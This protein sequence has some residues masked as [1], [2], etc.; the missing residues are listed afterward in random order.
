MVSSLVSFAKR[1]IRECLPG[2]QIANYVIPASIDN[3]PSI[4]HVDHSFYYKPN[5]DSPEQ[6]QIKVDAEQIVKSIVHM[7][8]TS[9]LEY[10]PEPAR[11]PA[12]FCVI[13]RAVT[14]DILKKDY[15]NECKLALQAQR[16]WFVALVQLADDDWRRLHNHS[17]V[18][19]IQR[20]AAESLGLKREWL[21][22]PEDEAS[23]EVGVKAEACPFCAADLL[24][25]MAPICPTCGKVHN[26]KKLAE[27]EARISKTVQ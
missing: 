12:L 17:M 16:R 21:F 24:N 25:P 4:L 22:T 23:R 3:Q 1:D 9:Q 2:L 26:P 19:D 10:R 6:D 8:N 14:A 27:I 11:H 18:S 20:S 7:H 15:A 13:D 5:P